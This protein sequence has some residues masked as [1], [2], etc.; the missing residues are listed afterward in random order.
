MYC[1]EPRASSVQYGIVKAGVRA[2]VEE[3]FCFLLFAFFWRDLG[4]MR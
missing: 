1:L 3:P 4:A 2:A